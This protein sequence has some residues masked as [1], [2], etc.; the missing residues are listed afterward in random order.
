M[1]IQISYKF[2]GGVADGENLTG[3]CTLV[4]IRR[5]K[6]QIIFMIDA[7]LLQCDF[8]KSI[9]KNKKILDQVNL[10]LVDCI[11]ITHPHIDHIGRLPLLVKAGFRGEILCMEPT[12]DLMRVMLEDTVKILVSEAKYLQGKEERQEKKERKKKPGK[13]HRPK[14]KPN[15]WS[16]SSNNGIKP[17]YTMEDVEKTLAFIKNGGFEYKKPIK[18]STGINLKFYPSGHVLGGAVC[19]I[20]IL[21][22]KNVKPIYLGFSGDLG[23]EDGII[24]PPP[25]A[26]REPINYWL[27]EST[28]GGKKHPDRE[29]EIKILLGVVTD[30]VKN[31]K[32]VIIP[33]FALE[34]TQEIVFLLSYY[35][36]EKDI[37]EIPIYLDSPMALRISEIYGSYWD[38]KMFKNQ[39]KLLFNPFELGN[40]YLR[41]IADHLASADLSK[42]PGPYIVIAGSGMCDAGRVRNHL[43]ENLGN[44]NAVV[45]LIGYMAKGS[46]GRKLQEGLPIV[47]MNGREIDVNAQIINFSSYSAHADSP[48]LVSYTKSAIAKTQPAPKKIFIVHGEEA[49]GIALKN[50]LREVLPGGNWMK[51]VVIPALNEVVT[52][53]M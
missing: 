28:Y 11:I 14:K 26:I 20:K 36:Q 27:I 39:A 3:S 1:K 32:K 2:L 35:M 34:R 33:S 24:L 19:V 29:Q 44:P 7:G 10:S 52:I 37:P 51:D 40:P 22:S 17:L 43:R 4:K 8:R 15:G 16:K 9:E 50:E 31:N 5:G 42:S 48:H 25:A 46:L 47:K 18:L 12:V 13:R 41:P 49:G 21:R 38:S 6:K 30:A 45:C 23:R 53:D